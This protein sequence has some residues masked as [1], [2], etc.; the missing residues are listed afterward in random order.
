[1]GNRFRREGIALALVALLALAGCAAGAS[2]TPQPTLAAGTLMLPTATPIPTPADPAGQALLR[3]AQGAVG[4][5]AR[6]VGLTYDT[7]T[8]Q[9]TAT[10]LIDGIIPDT[11]DRIAAAYTRVKTLTFQVERALWASGQPLRQAQVIVMGPAQDEYGEVTDQWYGIA[12]LNA[13]AARNIAWTSATPASAWK[14]YDQT[15]LRPSFT[16]ADDIITGPAPTAT[17]G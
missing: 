2:A 12:V 15:F 5:V 10:I 16:V 6:S 8:Q 7:T 4:A 17:P 11:D 1:M 14:R 3:A 13:P 9:A